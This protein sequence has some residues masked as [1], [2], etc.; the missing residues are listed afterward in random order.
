MGIIKDMQTDIKNKI[1]DLC[2]HNKNDE[3]VKL[4]NSLPD[5]EQTD[6]IKSLLG[7]AYNN[8]ER[9]EEAL[10][11][12]ISVK[13]GQADTAQWNFRV[14]Y[15][16]FYLGNYKE[17]LWYFK[18]ALL[19]DPRNDDVCW[20][21]AQCELKR[22]FTDR[23]VEFWDWFQDH[24]D[25][26]EILSKKGVGKHSKG[27]LRKLIYEWLHII[28]SSIDC[29]VSVRDHEIYFTI[30]DYADLYM[31]PYIVKKVPSDLRCQWKVY[32][33]RQPLPSTNIVYSMYGKNIS[34]A[35]VMVQYEYNRENKYFD[36]KYYHSSLSEVDDIS[37]KKMFKN[38]FDL[39]LGVGPYYN[40]INNIK[41]VERSKDMFPLTKLPSVIKRTLEENGAQYRLEPDMSSRKYKRHPK[42]E[43]NLV[44]F[45]ITNGTSNCIPLIDEYYNGGRRLYDTFTSCGI[46]PMMIIIQQPEEMDTNDFI[47]YMMGVQEQIEEMIQLPGNIEGQIIGNAYGG[48]GYGYI[49]LLVYNKEAFM[50]FLR[51]KTSLYSILKFPKGM[52][53]IAV[54]V[55]DLVYNGHIQRL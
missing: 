40:Y 11:V 25:E 19:L 54:F 2:D 14:G 29:Q 32:G 9:Y 10:D 27:K 12:L 8:L 43:D 44:R 46:A 1:K 28:G 50:K 3:A 38:M 13:G 31:N 55:E 52:K 21:I 37:S 41:Q 48:L 45:D 35:D 22:P 47:E 6:E 24:V 5:E 51:N 15:A 7:R 26:I 33:C 20:F 30:I 16:Y 53:K 42:A 39:V 23:V 18:E 17:A 49:D 36:L 4:I 34:V